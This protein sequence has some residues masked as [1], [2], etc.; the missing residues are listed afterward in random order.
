MKFHLFIG[1]ATLLFSACQQPSPNKSIPTGF[2]MNLS[3]FNAGGITAP[4]PEKKPKTLIAVGGDHRTDEYY[5]L[6]ERENPQVV[7]YLNAENEYAD[8]ILSPVKDLREHLFT[9]MKARIKEDDNSAPYLSKGY[10]YYSRYET[11]KEYVLHCRKKEN[12]DAPEEIMLDVNAMAV[13]KPYCSVSGLNVSPDGRFVF[14][15]TDYTGRNLFTARIKDLQTGQ[16]LP[17]EFDSAF[18]ASAWSKDGKY[19]FYDTKDKTTL[20]TDKVWRHTV[21]TNSSKDVLVH[22]DKDETIYVGVQPSKDGEY[23]FITHGYTQNM[24][25]IYLQ[26]DNPTGAFQAILPRTKDFFYDVE[27]HDGRF[28]IRTNAE[29]HN[30]S[31]MT[32]PANQPERANWTTLVPHRSDALIDFIDVYKDFVAISERNGG[33]QKINIYN[34]T[35]GTSHYID[36]GEPTYE[37]SPIPLPDATAKTLRYAFS[38]LKTPASV[39]D[40]EVA[41][42]IKTL[43]K[44]EP[45]P[46]GYDPAQYETEFVW[47]TARD[48]VKVP[49]SVV[50]KK[51]LVRDG[52]APCFQIGYGSYGSSYDPAFNKTWISLLDRGFVCAIAHIRGGMEMGY[53]WYIQ[54]KMKNKIN[55]FNDF[56]DCSEMLIKEKYTAADRLFAQGGSA[57]GLLMGAVANMRPDLYKGLIASVPFVDV[58]TTMSDPSIPLTTGEYAEWGNPNIKEEYNY[59]KQYSPYDNVKKQ[60]YPNLLV[61]TSFA[62]SQVQYFE[63]AKWVARLRDNKT[64]QHLLLFVTNMSGS[65]GGSSGR[66]ERLKE[67]A[68]E[69]AWMLGLLGNNN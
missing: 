15:V 37:A 14:F 59:M 63:P 2:T 44:T 49:V 25:T 39:F 42:K 28:I 46:G 8:S 50:Y 58:L 31:V 53:D 41:T 33:L 1:A 57:G 64:D 55:T 54:G 23:V 16:L 35:D 32:A 13:G 29:G 9:E 3:V 60:A 47:A 67:R 66:F 62:D 48:G 10:W 61:K 40:Y 43:K 52:S 11:G 20:R 21:G 6:N 19:L 36:F 51:G 68:M 26:L 45:V 24:E 7:A 22:E 38:S 30:F 65:H 27:H 56:I 17:D 34:W 5:W 12:M 18:G 69:Y 4:H